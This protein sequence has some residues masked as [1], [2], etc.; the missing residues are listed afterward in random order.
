MQILIFPITLSLPSQEVVKCR[1]ISFHYDVL[2]MS[3]WD[4]RGHDTWHEKW[5]ISYNFCHNSSESFRPVLPHNITEKSKVTYPSYTKWHVAVYVNKDVTHMYFII[6]HV[7]QLFCDYCIVCIDFL[8][9]RVTCLKVYS[10][11]SALG[12]VKSLLD[13][14]VDIKYFRHRSLPIE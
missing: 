6:R 2:R 10:G 13:F 12:L 7:N 1:L 9:I 11:K 4:N 14:K 5:Y 3:L 8:K